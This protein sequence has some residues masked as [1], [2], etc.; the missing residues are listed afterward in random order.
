MPIS[1]PALAQRRIAAAAFRCLALSLFGM[2]VFL[3]CAR[4]RCLPAG[5]NTLPEPPSSIAAV[6]GVPVHWAGG[7]VNYYV[8][9][10]PLNSSVTN[11]QATAMVDAAAALWSA[12]PTAGVTLTD[13]GPLNEDVNGSNIQVNSGPARSPRPPTSRPRP[14]TI[15]S[16]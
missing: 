3:L 12:V 14:P 11:Q 8:D 4:I 9:Q 10:G 13:M 1:A 2:A 6:L 5:P 15:P 16:P 7:Q